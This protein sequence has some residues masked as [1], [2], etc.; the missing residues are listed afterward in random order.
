VPS[1]ESSIGQGPGRTGEPRPNVGPQAG[2]EGSDGPRWSPGR[3]ATRKRGNGHR[4]PT[5]G[6]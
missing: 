2:F 6:R 5:A 4:R 3:G 1:A